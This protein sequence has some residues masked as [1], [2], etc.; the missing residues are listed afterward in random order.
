M[1]QILFILIFWL[2]MAVHAQFSYDLQ[3]HRGARGLMPENTIPAMIKALD[4]GVTTLELDLAVTKDGIVIVSHEPWMNGII[5]LKPDGTSIDKDDYSHNIYQMS[6]QEVLAYDCGFKPHPG[7]PQQVKFHT[8]K[9]SLQDLFQEVEK[10][11][12]D[13]KLVPPNYNIEIKSLPD[14]DGVYHPAPPDFSDL[15]Y[16]L[17][18]ELLEWDRVTIQSFDF[19]VLQYFHKTYPDVRLAMLVENAGKFEVQLK[20]L[21][22][23]PAIY[24]PYYPALTAESVAILHEK[25]LKVIPW[26]VNSTEAMEKLLDMGVDG[27]I[28]DY[29]NLAPKK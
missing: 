20:E 2:P 7:F 11:V 17:L 10:Y 24:S 21:G 25:G 6:Y 5:C 13:H 22:F 3:G 23:K 8:R 26:T 27:I 12:A 15:V 19:R 18:H 29:P 9:P 14:G 16:A 28:T 4:L 1:R